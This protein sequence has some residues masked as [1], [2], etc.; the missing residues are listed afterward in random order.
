MQRSWINL[1]G[2]GLVLVSL[3]ACNRSEETSAPE[4]DQLAV[5]RP[6]GIV[7]IPEKSALR[8]RLKVSAARAY[9][10]GVTLS[11][12]ASIEADPAHF[13]RIYPPLSGHVQTLFVRFGDRVVKGQ[14]LLALDSAD[15]TAAQNDY[16]KARSVADLA[17][18]TLS[19]QRDLYEHGIAAKREVEQAENDS[20]VAESEF[21]RAAN[22]LRTLGLNPERAQFGRAMTIYSPVAGR[23]VDMSV[24][25][26][27]YRNDA[28]APMMTIADLSTVWLT[29]NVQEKD[30]SRIFVG[31]KVDAQ[32]AAFLQEQFKG[33]VLFI[34][35]LLDPDTRTIKVRVALPNPDGRLKPGMFATVGFSEPAREVVAVPTTAVFQD[36]DSSIV[37]VENKPWTFQRRPV[38]V[39]SQ[40][41]DLAL[42]KTGLSVGTRVVSGDGLL[43]K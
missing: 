28:T 37:F 19:R 34:G 7:Y 25:V 12:P 30:A 39:E 20:A 5:K 16:F 4:A 15:F 1:L 14:A 6:D 23:V 17:E 24:A 43:I 31:Q 33:T 41:G 11:T 10:A 27:E 22:R 36:G 13:A 42:L 32:F 26:G 9:T 2:A 8:Q 18:R 38:T 21:S 35:D 3:A 40:Q 29:A